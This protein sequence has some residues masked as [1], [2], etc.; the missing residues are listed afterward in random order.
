MTNKPGFVFDTNALICLANDITAEDFPWE[1]LG[2]PQTVEVRTK[3]KE[4]VVNR[5]IVDLNDEGGTDA[6]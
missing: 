4:L 6:H 5:L 2:L 1:W 3:T